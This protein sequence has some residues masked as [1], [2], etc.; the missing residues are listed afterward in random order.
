MQAPI[1]QMPLPVGLYR[2]LSREEIEAMLKVLASEREKLEKEKEDMID[3]ILISMYERDKQRLKNGPSFQKNLEK[4]FEQPRD[5]ED[6]QF[7]KS[8]TYQE[9]GMFL[10]RKLEHNTIRRARLINDNMFRDISLYGSL[11]ESKEGNDLKALKEQLDVLFRAES[12]QMN[13]QVI[14][15]KDTPLSEK[16]QT[17]WNDHNF[18]QHDKDEIK[19][20]GERRKEIEIVERKITEVRTQLETLCK[21]VP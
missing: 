21:S 1:K 7:S 19:L 8:R 17:F 20:H 18:Y 10:D 12:D 15:N 2:S 5:Y 6:C 3:T 9:Q 16:R 13:A 14:I 4:F 11:M